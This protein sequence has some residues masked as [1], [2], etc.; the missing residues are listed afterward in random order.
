M[1][2][3]SVTRAQP[4]LYLSAAA[5]AVQ[6]PFAK[7]LA[8]VVENAIAVF[9]ES[10]ARA[11][12]DFLRF[13]TFHSMGLDPDVTPTRETLERN[14]LHRSAAPSS[15]EAGVMNDAA[16]ADVNAVMRVK[17]AWGDEMCGKRRFAFRCKTPDN[18]GAALT[19]NVVLAVM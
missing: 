4:T 13:E 17:R 11:S 5:V 18:S 3:V 1:G 16:V 12:H 6:A 8:V 2:P 10:R 15:G 19:R 7:V 9:A 14:F